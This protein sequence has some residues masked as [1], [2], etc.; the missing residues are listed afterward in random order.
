MFELNEEKKN[1]QIFFKYKKYIRKK[2]S[3]AVVGNNISD[4]SSNKKLKMDSLLH[5]EELPIILI[6]EHKIVFYIMGYHK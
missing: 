5:D 3:V 2:K 4:N 1:T 6:Q